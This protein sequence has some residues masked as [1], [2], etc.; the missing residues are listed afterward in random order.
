[1][2]E[3]YIVKWKFKR[4]GAF[5]DENFQTQVVYSHEELKRLVDTQCM[6]INNKKVINQS[7]SNLYII[8]SVNDMKTRQQ[9]EY[10]MIIAVDFTFKY[11]IESNFTNLKGELI[12]LYSKCKGV[13]DFK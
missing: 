8:D 10:G 4:G 2:R 13:E 12:L 9:I 1:M 11:V 3:S 6:K 7:D 5:W